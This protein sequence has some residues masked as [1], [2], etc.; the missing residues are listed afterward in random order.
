MRLMFVHWL[1]EDRGSAQDVH[2]YAVAARALGHEVALY[3]PPNPQS[4]FNYSMDM[5]SADAVIFIF[6]WTTDLQFGDRLDWMRLVAQVPRERRV[7]T[8]DYNHASA[9]ESRRWI[10]LCDSISD[11]IYQPTFHP[12]RSNVRTFFFHAYNPQWEIPL[13][14]TDKEFGMYYVGH[15]WFRWRP[16]KR[17]LRALEPVRGQVGR[18]GMV[19]HG[20]GVAPPWANSSIIEDAYYSDGEYL[21]EL[22][23][24]VEPPILFGQVIQHMSRGVF[25]PVIYRPLFNHLKL[26]TCRTFETPAA[27]TIPLF[28]LEESYVDELYGGRA[29][30]LVLPESGADEKILDV[31]RR[32][33]Y[34]AGI[35]C[36]I[37]RRLAAEY[38]Y[39]A[40]LERLLDIVKN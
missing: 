9:E 31:L 20:W 6:E 37:R 33:D 28:G 32:P 10:E 3:G 30:E 5:G 18:V 17:V 1:Y 26:V 11:K 8:G 38:S 23:I 13:D 21:R 12:L 27:N 15:N 2:N 16:M 39:A 25:H 40:S 22:N 24:E 35:V 7:V 29:L 19:G 14:F 4:P 34:Y 36:Q